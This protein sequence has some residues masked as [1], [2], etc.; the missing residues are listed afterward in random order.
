MEI[1]KTSLQDKYNSFLDELLKKYL[2]LAAKDIHEKLIDHFEISADY[3]R[4]IVGR[5]VAKNIIKSSKPST[6][7]NG[8]FIYYCNTYELD[9]DSI[10]KIAER[11]RPPIYRLIILLELNEGIVSYYEALKI[12]AAPS[13]D[14]STKISSLDDIIK[15]LTRLDFIYEKRDLNNNRY[16]IQKESKEVFNAP[17]E[18]FMMSTHYQKMIMDCNLIPDI[19]SWLVNSNII[20]NTS[21]IYRNKRN[22]AL[23]IIHNNL[24]WDACAYTKST[25]INEILGAKAVSKEKQTLVVLDIVLATEYSQIHLDAFLAR[26]QININS[27]KKDKRK[28]LPIIIYRECSKEVFFTMRK[29][30][31]ISFNLSAIFGSKIFEILK[32]YNQLPFLLQNDQNL[33]QSV[34]S[35]LESIKNS[36]QE[37]ALKDLRGTLF[38]YLMY[39]FLKVLYPQ[40][41]FEQNVILKMGLRKHEFDYI[42]NSS[43][44]PEI[45]FVELKGLRDGTFVSLGDTKTKATL[46]WFFNKSMGLAKEFYKDKNP[47]NYKLKAIFI[48]SAGYWENTKDFIEEMD[49]STYRSENSKTIIGRKELIENL[50]CKGFSNEVKMIEKYYSIIQDETDNLSDF[51]NDVSKNDESVDL[52]F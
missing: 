20:D 38:E 48:T 44:P 7:G 12:T 25:G 21:F 11:T 24:F 23:G 51:Y 6:F 13:E 29:N 35:I 19:M 34:E 40:A 46:K 28:T 14:A 33:D 9:R 41:T 18:Y 8:Q 37:G 36:G 42:I 30:G 32:K 49:N 17:H 39:P 5:A 26:I 47:K 16:I 52:P 31:I 10:K 27:V 15:I 22:P 4:K 45:I 1:K 2:Y 43:H 50:T 3:S